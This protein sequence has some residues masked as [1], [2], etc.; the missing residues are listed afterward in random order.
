MRTQKNARLHQQ[1]R[2][3]FR[4]HEHEHREGISKLFE[5]VADPEHRNIIPRGLASCMTRMLGNETRRL[6][7]LVESNVGVDAL[8]CSSHNGV[9]C[10]ILRP[11]KA[12]CR[13]PHVLNDDTWKAK[14]HLWTMKL[15]PLKVILYYLNGV[16][17]PEQPLHKA[18]TPQVTFNFEYCRTMKQ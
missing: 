13:D 7:S 6:T 14:Y 12:T 11:N 10:L 4:R 15:H 9:V 8:K 16:A 18:S 3:Y 1:K 17:D 2:Q 5:G